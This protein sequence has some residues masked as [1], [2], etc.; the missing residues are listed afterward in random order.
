MSKICIKPSK[1]SCAHSGRYVA[2]PDPEDIDGVQASCLITTTELHTHCKGARRVGQT[3]S[4]VLQN[5][6]TARCFWVSWFNAQT[7][8]KQSKTLLFKVG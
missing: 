1:Y 7:D 4:R 2:E 5:E 3:Y 6:M 8:S